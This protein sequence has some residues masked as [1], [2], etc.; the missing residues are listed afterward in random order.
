M[1]RPGGIPNY[2]T[3]ADSLRLEAGDRLKSGRTRRYTRRLRLETQRPM[4]PV[5]ALFSY[6]ETHRAHMLAIA[7]LLVGLVAAVDYFFFEA[8]I[9][10]LYIVP[11]V[12]AAASLGWAQVVAL[13]VVCTALRQIV[14]PGPVAVDELGHLSVMMAA[15][16]LAG[17]FVSELNGRRRLMVAHLSEVENQVRLR[18][19]AEERLR[20][21]VET[22]PLAIL[23]IE[24]NG[25]VS[26]AN[27]SAAQMLGFDGEEFRGQY[28]HPYLPLLSRLLPG[29]GPSR[30][31]RTT[32]ECKGQRKDGEVFL[33]Q[34]WL[35]SIATSSGPGLAAVVWDASENLR[36]REGAGL[37]SM[38]ATS[39]IVIGA[40][41]HEI[42]NLAS[43]G[44]SAHRSLAAAAPGVES[45]EEYAAL[46]SIIR[47]VEHIAAS[48]LAMH[49]GDAT[50]VADLG[51]VLD[52][53]RIVIDASAQE[54]GVKATWKIDESL[55]LVH[56][57]QYRLLQV[58]LNLARNSQRAM[59]C[60]GRKELTVEARRE[61]D[62]LAV[63]FYDTGC[64]V[65]HPD[66]LFHPFQ[67]GASETG[68]GLYVSRAI[69]RA[70]G[71]DLSFQAQPRGACFTVNLSPAQEAMFP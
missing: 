37:E 65:E 19:N 67:P 60:A 16:V 30:D 29:D 68:L 5:Q 11:I 36:E 71:G 10:Y 21:L 7:G 4:N 28:V 43:A 9:A 42:R 14:H 20:V 53:A 50:E 49:A 13:A 41:A 40:L 31:V 35:S 44:I 12:L 62:Q 22:S 34:V 27:R 70:Y 39:R 63:R 48:G 15:F 66:E 64:G 51:T 26:L 25:R 1:P 8:S 17:A 52:E 18:N 47:G 69:L 24:A 56:A 6:S 23:I 46:G 33:A 3:L 32:V 57:G 61:G 54:A 59:E 45:A 2:G 38:L 55:P 58:F